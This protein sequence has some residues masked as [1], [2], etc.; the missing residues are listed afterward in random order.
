MK[1]SHVF[2]RFPGGRYKAVSFTFDDGSEQDEWVVGLL[3]RLGLKGTFNLNMGLLPPDDGFDFSALDPAV[4]PARDYCQRRLSLRR[5]CELFADSGMELASHGYLHAELTR[6]DDE[7]VLWE[8]LRDRA[9]LEH[10]T[11]ESVRG[12]AYPQGAYNEHIANILRSAGIEYART[13]EMS[14]S[15]ALPHDLMQWH[16]TCHYALEDAMA[17]AEKF[18]AAAPDSGIYMPVAEAKLFT[19]FGHS[20]ELEYNKNYDKLERLA[21]A[22]AHMEDTWYCTFI[23]Y[24]RYAHAFASLDYDLSRT[25][26]RNDSALP[27]W[28]FAN[29]RVSEVPPGEVIEI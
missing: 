19:V 20:Y 29:G 1:H 15:F 12:F 6:L 3:R 11:G 25:H 13:A 16:P 22:L 9:E 10:I 2:M 24:S 8:V 14:G 26:V 17:L 23:E 18:R 4:F 28:I 5:I 7:G 27:V 21:D